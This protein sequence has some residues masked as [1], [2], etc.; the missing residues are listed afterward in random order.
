MAIFTFMTMLGP[1]IGP[2]VSGFASSVSWHWPFWILVMMMRIFLPL[3]CT[4]PETYGS[5]LARKRDSNTSGNSTKQ[6][7]TCTTVCHGNNGANFT[8]FLS[9]H[10]FGIWHTSYPIIFQ[11][12]QVSASPV[13]TDISLQVPKSAWN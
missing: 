9:S 4:L 2:I 6:P 7:F 10:G 12:E 11:G 3:L 13:A 1:Q 5:V 8:I